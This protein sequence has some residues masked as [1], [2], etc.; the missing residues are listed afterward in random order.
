V[1]CRG[2]VEVILLALPSAGLAMFNY[3]RVDG[4]DKSAL[5]GVQR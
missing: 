4:K 5:A 3:S 2:P 1:E